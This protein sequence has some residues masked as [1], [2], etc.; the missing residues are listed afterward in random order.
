VEKAFRLCGWFVGLCLVLSLL[1]PGAVLADDDDDDDWEEP[2]PAESDDDDDWEEDDDSPAPSQ[3]VT[4]DDDDDR[5]DDGRD[6]DG[7]DE[8]SDDDSDENQDGDR[9]DDESDDDDWDQTFDR[10]VPDQAI[11]QLQL[12]VDP[13]AFAARY[14]AT[15]LRV[16]PTSNVVLLQLDPGMDDAGELAGMTSDGDVAWSEMNFTNQAPEGRPRY[17]F[18]STAGESQIVNAPALPDGLDFTPEMSCATG[19]SVIVAV[20][21]TGIDVSHPDLVAN[22]LPNG[23]DTLENTSDVRDIGNEIDDDGDGQIDEMVGHGTN[24]AGIVVQIAPEARILPV[25]VLNSDGVGNTFSV[26]SGIHYAVEQGADVINLS[27][28]TTLDSR[29]IREAVAYALAEGVVVAAAA[30]NG[31]H[32]MPPEYPA[33]IDDVISVAATD[34]SGDKASYS[35]YHE[36]V[37]ISA[38]GDNVAS[39][40]PDGRYITASGTSMSTPLVAGAAALMLEPHP[41]ATPAQVMTVLQNT[42]EPLSL[43]DPT[44]EGLLGAGELDIDASISC[45]G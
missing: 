40:Y 24:V 31:D 41:G 16:I 11:A 17:F 44:L 21:D 9:A 19:D 12:G 38:P 30:G 37:D 7:D 34:A 29:A 5:D 2:V 8:D 3:P 10:E 32:Q 33:A 23:I 39:A 1:Q 25:K 43:S 4:T 22:V 27:L 13:N 35:N 42:S 14:G 28:G 18:T 20:L 45:N 15:V 36:S 6:D 26:V